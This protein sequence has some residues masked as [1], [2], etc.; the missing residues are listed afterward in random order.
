MTQAIELN[1][2]TYQWPNRP[3]RGSVHRRGRPGVLR[4]GTERRHPAQHPQ[5]PGARVQH[6]RARGDAQLHEPEQHVDSD[7]QSA[8]R[9]RHIGKL[10]SR[11]RDGRGTHDERS[12]VP[13]V[14]DALGKILRGGGEGRRHHCEGQAAPSS[15]S[16]ARLRERLRQLF[17]REVGHLHHGRERHRGCARYGRLSLAGRVLGRSVGLR[18][19]SGHQDSR[20]GRRRPHVPVADRL[21]PAQVRAGNA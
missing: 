9:S 19:R 7:R 21:H 14:G 16:R 3:R 17:F 10:F 2:V 8:V 11:S 20:T 18:A 15:R 13:P 5:V 6:G 12:R 4:A 1:G